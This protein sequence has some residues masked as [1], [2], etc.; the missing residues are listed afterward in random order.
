ME[1]KQL[2]GCRPT[3]SGGGGMQMLSYHVQSSKSNNLAAGEPAKERTQRWKYND[4]KK[5]ACLYYVVADG[6]VPSRMLL[7]ESFF[8]R[9]PS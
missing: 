4:N 3:M 7:T 8:R 1:G 6:E 5:R 2:T 9:P